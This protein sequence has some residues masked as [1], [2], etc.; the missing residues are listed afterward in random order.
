MS[1]EDRAAVVKL[2]ADIRE[3]EGRLPK[4]LPVAAGIRDGDY[5]FAPDGP[6]D[7][8]VPGTTAKRFKLDF[9]GSYIPEAGKPYVPPPLCAVDGKPLL[10]EPGF[11]TA[12]TEGRPVTARPPADGRATSGR[13]RA[14][15]EWIASDGNPLTARVMVNRLWHHHFGRGIVATASNFGKTGTPPTHPELLDWLA[16]EFVRQGW[17]CK[18]MHRLILTSR[19][20][21]MASAYSSAESLEK[22]PD[23]LYLWRFPIRRLE[24]EIIR[25]VILSA[26]GRLNL[27]AGGPPF[28]PALQPSVHEDAKKVGK[29]VL[30]KEEPSTWRRSIYSYW[31]RA[32]KLPMFEVFDAPDTMVTC[33]RRNTTTVPTQALTLMNNEFV[34]VQSRHLA[35]RVLEKA[36]ADSRAQVRTAY[37]ICLGRDPRPKELEIAL[38]FLARQRAYHAGRAGVDAARETLTD[39]SN[40]ILNLNEFVYV[41]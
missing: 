27:E 35:A 28:F 8:P 18:R 34:L 13:R 36:G 33:E 16:T 20:Y 39:L 5:R 23:N 9:R 4:P 19:T 25:D 30:T 40:V 31:K 2:E 22:D 41:N 14:L 26:S 7:E 11:L 38:G 37:R 24:A 3:I 15:A 1:P 10:L 12:V 17:S 21:Q 29:W 32:L 6:G